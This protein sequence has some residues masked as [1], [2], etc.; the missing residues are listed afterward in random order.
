MAVGGWFLYN[1][2]FDVGYPVVFIF[3]KNMHEISE[4]LYVWLEGAM[5][6]CRPV[7][8]YLVMYYGD[9]VLGHLS[10]MCPLHIVAYGL[11]KDFR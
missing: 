6:C 4:I 7:V 11:L 5:T 2:V 8:T 10:A 3:G 1:S 9:K